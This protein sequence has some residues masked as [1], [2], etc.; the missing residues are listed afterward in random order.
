M[1]ILEE[2]MSVVFEDS[3][4]DLSDDVLYSVSIIFL[5]LI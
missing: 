3:Q 5:I 4:E 1:D 2:T